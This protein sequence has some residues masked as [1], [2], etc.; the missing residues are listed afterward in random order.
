MT[1]SVIHPFVSGKADGGDTSLVRPSNWNDEH[2][3]TMA[4]DKLLGRG[5]AGT[6]AVEEITLGSNLSLA[7]TTL[8]VVATVV[9]LRG[10]IDGLTLSWVSTTSFSV[11]AGQ[12]ADSTNAV[13]IDLASAITKTTSTWAVGSGNGGIDTGTIA[14]NTWY[15]VH[16]IRRSDTGVEDVLFSLSA[17]SPTMPTDYDQRRR[18]GSIKT[19]GSSQ[20]IDFVQTGDEFLWKGSFNDAVA[21]ACSETSA[22]LAMTV[23]TGVSVWAKFSALLAASDCYLYFYPLIRGDQTSTPSTVNIFL[24]TITAGEQSGGD[25]T[26]QTNTSAQ[27]GVVANDGVGT[28]FVGTYGWIDRRGRNA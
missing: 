26:I 7:G 19:N 18:I 25:F 24:A 16:L 14:A 12:A 27:I 28:Y 17:T 23:P 6:G 1:I 9:V 8:N 11:A 13:L 10:H 3:F 15:H 21:V 5:T 20:F 22:A 4:T 2:T